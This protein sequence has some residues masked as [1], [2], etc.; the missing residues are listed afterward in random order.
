MP[1]SQPRAHAHTSADVA[2][3]PAGIADARR[4]L[5]E[6]IARHGL[7]PDSA[8]VPHEARPE[9]LLRIPE[10]SERVWGFA[11]PAEGRLRPSAVLILFGAL[12]DVPAE[13]RDAAVDPLVD[14]LLTQRAETLRTHA[15]QVAF[16]GG[17]VDPGDGSVIVTALREAAEETGLDPDGVEVLGVLPAVPVSVSGHLVHP[18]IGWWSDPSRVA[19]VDPDEATAVFRVPVADLVAP[20]NRVSVSPEHRR[21]RV[22]PGFL[23]Q[24]RLVWGFT[25]AL[26]TR[27]LRLLRW[28]R[29][30]NPGAVIDADTRAPLD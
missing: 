27:V 18:V 7:A 8:D 9:S 23:V 19:V 15:G 20:E 12:D 25:G 22:T 30:W 4:A 13:H 14:V 24:D 17:R 11:W 16:P 28:D 5:V 10:A 6:L 26:L 3:P 29:P 2:T 1:E 21:D